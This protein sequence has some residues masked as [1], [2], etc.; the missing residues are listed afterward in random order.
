MPYLA[1]GMPSVLQQ[2]PW[3]LNS[4]VDTDLL[5]VLEGSGDLA[6]LGIL[7]DKFKHG[8]EVAG[9]QSRRCFY[10]LGVD[11]FTFKAKFFSR[12]LILQVEEAKELVR[13]AIHAGIMSD[14][15]SG[16]NVDICV[17]TREGVDYIRPYQESAYKDIR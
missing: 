4:L 15:G 14:L 17:I 8:M 2:S 11:E 5:C 6:A 10:S 9:W 16:N 3:V 1:M 12:C 13:L 7:E